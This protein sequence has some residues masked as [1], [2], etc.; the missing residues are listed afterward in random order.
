[1]LLEVT[2]LDTILCQCQLLAVAEIVFYELI[3]ALNVCLKIYKHVFKIIFCINLCFLFFE[4]QKVVVKLLLITG[5]FRNTQRGKTLKKLHTQNNQRP[6]FLT[7]Y[8]SLKSISQVQCLEKMQCVS[9]RHNL[10]SKTIVS[11]TKEFSH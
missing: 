3:F 4:F 7:A 1:M 2:A 8:F 5:Q 10:D 11:V 6:D 9:V